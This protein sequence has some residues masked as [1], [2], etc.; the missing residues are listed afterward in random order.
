MKK[1]LT[2]AI[3]LTIT[4]LFAGCNSETEN[5]IKE[6]VSEQTETVSEE[7]TVVSETIAATESVSETTVNETVTALQT[8][9]TTEA[10]TFAETFSDSEEETQLP[11]EKSVNGFEIYY[12]S[13]EIPDKCA[14]RTAQYFQAMQNIDTEKYES[15]LI[16]LYRDYLAEYL[17]QSDYTVEKLLEEYC[18]SIKEQTG[19]D[20]TYSRAELKRLYDEDYLKYNIPDYPEEY[21]KQLDEI[22]YKKDGTYISETFDEYFGMMCDIYAESGGNEHKI[23]DSGVI[24]VFRT[25][26]EYYI[27]IS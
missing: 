10:E 15:M 17:E 6:T 18:N 27:L 3:F 8:E 22:S 19:G 5:I 2:A 1:I 12:N 23:I 24:S 13:E 26:E 4:M 11:D 20:F 21:I 25:G 14:E 7:N 9:I 16:P